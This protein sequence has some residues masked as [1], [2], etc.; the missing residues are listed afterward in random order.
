MSKRIIRNI[1]NSHNIIYQNYQNVNVVYKKNDYLYLQPKPSIGG[2]LKNN[3][4]LDRPLTNLI[5]VE[6][7]DIYHPSLIIYEPYFSDI[8]LQLSDGKIY[9]DVKYGGV[10]N[11]CQTSM[12]DI[13][14]KDEII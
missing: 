1:F 13:Y 11:G 9:I 5:Y 6:S 4:K 12:I 2:L 8:L 10:K 7:R 14:V 3:Y